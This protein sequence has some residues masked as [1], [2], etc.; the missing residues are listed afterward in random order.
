M[1]AAL[2]ATNE[3]ILHSTSEQ[4][5]CQRVCDAAGRHGGFLGTAIFLA[6]EDTLRFR[7]AAAAG[8]I[9]HLIEKMQVSRDPS[10]PA[11]QGLSAEAFRTG[12][13][14]VCNDVLNDPRTQ[15]WK[16]LALAG[17]LKALAVMP[18]QRDGESI[19]VMY[20][21]SG[22]SGLDEDLTRLMSSMTE[23]VAFGMQMFHRDEQRNRL[24]RMLGALSATNEAIMRA[25]NRDE[26][27]QL[28]CD[29]VMS[30]AAFTATI[31]ALPQPNSD[32]LRIVATSG[33]QAGHARTLRLAVT[34]ERPE[35]RGMAGTTFRTGEPCF[36]NNMRTDERTQHWHAS[37]SSTLS[38]GG[39]PLLRDGKAI[40]V[41]LFL[42]DKI[43]AFTP[44][45]IELLQRLAE[46]VSFAMEMLE[47]DEGRR[48][49]ERAQERMTRMFA[50][51][52]ATNEAIMRAKTRSELF[53]RVC[54]AAVLGGDFV[55]TT[56]ALARPGHEFL[57]FVAAAGSDRDRPASVRS[58]VDGSRPEGTGLAGR[59]FRSR[60]PCISNDY[61]T[62][63]RTAHFHDT[64]RA[65]GAR[66]GA[67]LPL[68]KGDEAVGALMF[69]STEAGAFTP[70]LVELLQ[71]L[72]ENVSFGL[73]N[74]DRAEEK[75]QAEDH[76]KY[77]ATHDG[78][79][80]LPNRAMFN[81]LLKAAIESAR[82][83]DR[84][85]ALLFV[86]LD[87]FK[88][89]NDTLGHADG[90]A[91]LIE[92]ATR[93]KQCLRATDVVARLGGDEFVV[94]LTDLKDEHYANAAA[95]KLLSC[96]MHPIVLR[97]QECRVT[98]SIGVAIFPENGRDEQ[99]LVK[100]ADMAMYLAKEEGKN[101]VRFF[102]NDM[103]TQS[104]ER[105]MMEN[106]L[107]KALERD[108]FVL[109][110][111]PKIDL[112]TGRITGVEALLRW[113]QPDL[114]M[115]PPHQFIPL[116]EETGL[117]VPIGRWV[118]KTACAQH[119][120]WQRQGFPPIYMAVNISPR[121]FQHDQLLQDID[122]TLAVTGMRPEL[123]ELEVTE[124]MV[125]QNVD[126]AAVLLSSIK[127][128]GVRLAM[129]DFG[130]GY[131]S[132]SLI[133][134]F[135]IDTLKIDRSFVRELPENNDD[136]AIADAIIG[137]G[138]A[139]GVTIVAE[140]VETGGQQTFLRDHACDEMQGYLFS[141]PMPADKIPAMMDLPVL[142][143]PHLQP[144]DADGQQ[145]ATTR[146][147]RIKMTSPR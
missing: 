110:Y 100:N 20:F 65:S 56:I 114:G 72:A 84:Q 146:A 124:S 38:C 101:D 119:V 71:R 1:F 134:R 64:I 53:Q 82:R 89:I 123:L 144:L 86:D 111:Q 128:R 3:A 17:G 22:E 96:V 40:G 143:S 32:F 16:A 99:T 147:Q 59:A 126:R 44:R 108:E 4:D 51:L 61:L 50:A 118:L 136:K 66:S 98:A 34:A 115:L 127:E 76:I 48:A 57:E 135:P 29:A 52:S 120:A 139:L 90:D 121:Q 68:L 25:S 142:A 45:L 6:E 33:P 129:D 107:R 74:F 112:K 95:R 103:K 31:I 19:G 42:S 67:A 41:L 131:S 35:G 81:Q 14:C 46:N 37:A 7:L 10:T 109:H 28:V 97:G 85:L 83:H 69:L 60:Q 105:L 88:I 27:F 23:N 9:V 137:L 80:D 47:R 91:L 75:T 55:S 54:E 133:K 63:P 113:N 12:K 94:I 78:L 132:M 87:R 145:D 36:I 21:F 77:L 141:R 138:K 70:E 117:I 62:D 18:L 39:I 15:P 49:A 30:E 58:S 11:G 5:L 125:M 104:I 92:V 73:E 79:T 24:A 140:G 26:L 2:S 93:L 13:P 106:N 43:G 102:S 8:S 130:T 122:E 116:A